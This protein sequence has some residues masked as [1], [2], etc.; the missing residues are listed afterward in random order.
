MKKNALLVF[1]LF[2]TVALLY[3]L[4]RFMGMQGFAFA[5][6]LNF[7]LMACTFLFTET[8]QSPFNASY[9]NPKSWERKGRLYEL[10]GINVYRKFLVVTGWEKIHKK[11][12]PVAKN[13]DVLANL[14]YRS[15]QDETGHLV[16]AFIVMGFTFFV[17]YK[18]GILNAAW[19]LVLNILLNVYPVFLQR[20]NR[21]RIERALKLSRRLRKD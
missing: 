7:L 14:Y 12:K 4:I 2:I 13:T 11:T 21:P 9:F 5:F 19:L 17:C 10:L 3:A 8:L 20:Y 1:I 18:S 15:K 16:I 6:T